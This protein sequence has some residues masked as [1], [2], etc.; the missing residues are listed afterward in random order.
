M[1]TTTRARD[2]GSTDASTK[3]TIVAQSDTVYIKNKGAL[4]HSSSTVY[5]HNKSQVSNITAADDVGAAA[6]EQGVELP[7]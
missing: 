6:K 5:T 2:S 7:P 4:V 3:Y 1:T